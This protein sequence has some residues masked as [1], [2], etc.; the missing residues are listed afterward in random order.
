MKQPAADD[1]VVRRLYQ[2]VTPYRR[3][4]LLGLFCLVLAVTAELYPPLIWQQVV[5]VGLMQQ[6]WGFIGQQIALLVLVLGVGQ[7]F[8]AIRGV[9]LE[10]AAQRLALD[11]RLRL[12]AKLQRQSAAYFSNRRTGDLLARMAADVDVV[13]NVLVNGTDSVVASALR[14]VGVAAI[15]IYLQPILG[16]LTLLP[17]LLVGLLLLRYNRRVRPIY[18]AARA[19]LGELSARLND[20]I[21]GMR[22]IQAFAQERRE[23]ATVTQLGEQLY[24]E[25]VRAVQLRNRVFPVIRWIANLSNP[26][27]LV[28]G[29][30][31]ILRGQFTLGGLL[32][33]RGYGRYFYGPIDDLVSTNDM[34]QN[35]AAAARR[36]FEILDAP[37]TIA[38]AP[39]AQPLPAPLAGDI[40]FESVSFGYDPHHPVLRDVSLHLRPGERVAIL[41]PSGAGKSTLLALVARLYDPT[42][43]QVLLD[44]HDLR[45]VTLASLRGQLGQVQQET[46]L[47]N[48]SVRENLRYGR[49]DAND[50]AVEAAA[51]AANAHAFICGLP[52]GYDTLVGER[53]VKLSGGQRQRIAVARALLAD[54]PL[55][56]LDEPTSAVEPESEAL[57][58]EGLERLMH[59]KTT[60]IV[61]HRLSLARSA[62]RVLVIADGRVVEDGPPAQLLAKA[63]GYFAA[64][65]RADSAFVLPV[66]DMRET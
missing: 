55:L 64:M 39:D 56:L 62:D 23:T 24:D 52:Q 2:L 61:S 42:A 60:L 27:M 41:G 66:L 32:A 10:R 1:A 25:Q 48:A 45:E 11:L 51:R 63:D 31:F 14:L 18:R 19:H 7:F 53:G 22:V 57:I 3:T 40:R 43:G 37:E 30:Y 38:D 6:H 17:M 65:V 33:Y 8:S 20:N 34:V 13:Q 49:P 9:L 46:F 12:Y 44:R 28:G 21:G 29:V 5:D 47:F 15:F 54:P 59:G 4:I 35:A 36:I 58:I 50:H 16:S 26:I